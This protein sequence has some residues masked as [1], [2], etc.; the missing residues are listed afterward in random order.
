MCANKRPHRHIYLSHWCCLSWKKCTHTHRETELQ[1]ATA[2][3][4]KLKGTPRRYEMIIIL[5]CH[6]WGQNAPNTV[7]RETNATQPWRGVTKI[8][9]R[10]QCRNAVAAPS[11][12]CLFTYSQLTGAMWEREESNTHAMENTA[13]PCHHH[14]ATGRMS[15]WKKIDVIVRHVDFHRRQNS[16]NENV[17]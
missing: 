1:N 4:K 9:W 8:E 2:S 13:T 12:T 14:R 16:V 3:Q 5:A 10:T 17:I 11:A 7:L 15:L 6:C